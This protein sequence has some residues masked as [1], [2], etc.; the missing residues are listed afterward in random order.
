[1]GV[2]ESSILGSARRLPAGLIGRISRKERGADFVQRDKM[3]TRRMEGA[4][5]VVICCCIPQNATIGK[6]YRITHTGERYK[7]NALNIVVALA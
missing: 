1:M 4:C 5:N 3:K 7:L 6:V 2:S